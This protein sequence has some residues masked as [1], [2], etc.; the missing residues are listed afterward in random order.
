MTNRGATHNVEE[1]A[2]MLRSKQTEN[3]ALVVAELHEAPKG[4]VLNSVM[5]G[6]AANLLFL[7]SQLVQVL[8]RDPSFKEALAGLI[9]SNKPTPEE[10]IK[11]VQELID[12]AKNK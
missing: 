5:Q 12:R 9:E 7:L 3:S 4:K 2:A 1:A 6:S 11:Q 8:H 10:V